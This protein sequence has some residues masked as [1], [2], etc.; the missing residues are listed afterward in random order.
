IEKLGTPCVLKTATMGYDGKGQ[1]KIK[2]RHP[3]ESGDPEAD[4]ALP[5]IPAQGGDNKKEY[6][7]EAFVNFKMEISV[8][9]ARGENEDMKCYVPVENKHKNHILHETIVP[10]P[11]SAALA[12]RAEDMARTIAEGLGLVGIMAV[13]MFVTG[14]GEL[15]VNE[16]APRPHNSGHW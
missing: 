5:E 11:I 2:A 10:A 1:W 9:V 7:L 13:E 14:N 16:L 4:D 8:I 15:L 6:V 12:A 3:R